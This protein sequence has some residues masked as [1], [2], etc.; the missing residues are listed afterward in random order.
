[1]T[2]PA[3]AAPFAGGPNRLCGGLLKRPPRP[4]QPR[5]GQPIYKGSRFAYCT[6]S[7][8]VPWLSKLTWTRA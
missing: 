2:Q 1:M 7:H 3:K 8:F 4:V 5:M 6:I